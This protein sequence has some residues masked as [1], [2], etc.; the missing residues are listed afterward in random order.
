MFSLVLVSDRSR[1]I[2]MATN[3][4]YEID[5]NWRHAF[6]LRTRIPQRMAVWKSG[7][8]VNS[9][10][11]LP[12]SYNYLVNFGPLTPE[13]TMMVWRPF[14]HQIGEISE[15]HS[16]FGTCIWQWMAWAGTAEWI[17]AKFTRKTNGTAL[18]HITSRK[19]QVRWFDR[20]WEESS[21]ACVVRA[22]CGGPGWLPVGSAMHF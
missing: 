21:L 15:T 8:D 11:V 14:M 5:R 3:F 10:E 2:A 22:A 13:F 17:C 16:I 12:T 4:R 7:G 1:D 9:T 20:W 18:L 19:Q 6:L